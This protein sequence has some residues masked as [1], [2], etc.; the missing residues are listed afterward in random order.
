MNATAAPRPRRSAAFAIGAWALLLATAAA[1][2]PHLLAHPLRFVQHFAWLL[3]PSALPALLLLVPTLPFARLRRVG[4]AAA[5]VLFGLVGLLWWPL[6]ALAGWSG[7]SPFG[8]VLWIQ[9]EA[10]FLA[11]HP[12]L[13][14]TTW[15]EVRVAERGGRGVHLEPLDLAAEG[16]A[17]E[18]C[19]A[20]LGPAR[21]GGLTPPP[22]A[23]CAFSVRFRIRGHEHL[24]H[25]YHVE[26]DGR[27]DGGA[28]AHFEAWAKAAGATAGGS[29]IG[30]HRRAGDAVRHERRIEIADGTRV[31]HVRIYARD[32]DVWIHLPEGGAWAPYV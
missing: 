8:F 18:D 15:S 9:P 26:T 12:Q 20:G 3:V 31:W 1:F 23:R 30:H 16:F 10:D 29:F 5:L 11:R 17:F 13:E 2:E 27:G 25:V 6:V 21:L 4:V 22:G 32:R 24:R 14:V 7:P 28:A 19:P